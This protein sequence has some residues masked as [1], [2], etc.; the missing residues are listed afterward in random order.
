MIQF[1]R[2]IDIRDGK[3]YKTVLM[4][5]GNWWLA[6]DVVYAGTTSPYPGYYTWAEALEAVI[7]GCRMPKYDPS[8][9][10]TDWDTLE[11]AV[12]DETD[13]G[14]HLKT[15][16]GWT[17]N[18]I[19]DYG[20]S[21]T[22]NGYYIRSFNQPGPWIFVAGGENNTGSLY[23]YEWTTSAP[24][25]RQM[26][27]QND[28]PATST[29]GSLD[30]V[31]DQYGGGRRI[32]LRLIV[33]SGNIPDGLA[34]TTQPSPG[35]FST[36]QLVTI[37]SPKGAV[38]RYTTDGSIPTDS[39]PIYRGPIRLAAPTLIRAK[40]EGIDGVTDLPFVIQGRPLD[41]YKQEAL[42]TDGKASPAFITRNQ[43]L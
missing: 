22:R 31:Q 34:L 40:I 16:S 23:F 28:L 43:T 4:P 14:Y 35:T 20:F 39:S 13:A 10:I 9:G 29:T 7:P 25:F 33:E 6:E 12:G 21:A 2:K 42:F 15:T 26:F 37:V 24:W 19:D 36:P 17:A 41:A 11:E 8:N 5:D 38:V 18:G 30:K 1:G 3:A 27:I 32:S